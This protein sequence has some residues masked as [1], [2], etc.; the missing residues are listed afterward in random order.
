[1]PY[2]GKS[3]DLSSNNWRLDLQPLSLPDITTP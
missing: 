1:M 2:L 3:K